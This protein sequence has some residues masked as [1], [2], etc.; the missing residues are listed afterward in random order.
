MPTPSDDVRLLVNGMMYA[1][2]TSVRITVSMD[3]VA[4]SFELGLTDKWDPEQQP[5]AI[6]DGD[7][8]KVMIGD[9][10]VID[11]FVDVAEESFD[12]NDHTITVSGRDKTGDIVDCSAIN[13]PGEWKGRKI[14]QIAADICAPYGVKVVCDTDTGKPVQLFRLQPGEKCVDAIERMVKGAGMLIL[15]STR[16][17][18]LYITSPSTKQIAPEKGGVALIQGVNLMAGSHSMKSAEQYRNY[19]VKAYAKDQKDSEGDPQGGQD[20]ER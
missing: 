2:W 15:T 3:A 5:W 12:E 18:E 7:D 17:G 9:D 6:V 16:K 8:C 11:G 4:G 1:G 14:E 13:E 19:V 20:L 10:V